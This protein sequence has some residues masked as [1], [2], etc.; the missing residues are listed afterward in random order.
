MSATLIQ[1]EQR[2]VRLQSVAMVNT[3]GLLRWAQNGYKFKRDRKKLLR[4]FVDGFGGDSAPPADIYDK[5]L[6]GAINGM[7]ESL[8]PHSSYLDGASLQRLQTMI[9]GNY[10]GLGLSVVMDDGA[11][12]V[13]SPMHGSPARKLGANFSSRPQTGKL[14]A[15][16]CSATPRLGTSTWLPMKWLL[17]PS[18]IGGPSCSTLLLGRSLP[19]MEA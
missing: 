18:R 13:V 4:V 10:S 6:K 5:L 17:A 12:K 11:V 2:E 9:D 8:D 19:P 16:M 3:P 1:P 15:L 7:L 14:K